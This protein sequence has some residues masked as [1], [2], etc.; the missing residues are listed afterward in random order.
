[1]SAREP[2][3]RVAI[4]CGGTGGHLFPGVAV[5]DELLKRGL[6]VTLMISPKEVDQQAAGSASGVDV[7]TLPAAGLVRGGAIKFL[8]A[9][10]ASYRAARIEFEQ[11]P[12][13]AVLAMGGFTSAPPVLAARRIHARTFLHE[14]NTIPGRAN[15]WLSWLVNG[16]FT[17]FPSA[18][19]RLH[20]RSMK[21]TGTPVRPQLKR[22]DPAACRTAL[23]VEPSRPI[24][25]VVGGSQG[26]AGIND[27]VLRMLPLVSQ[28]APGWQ[29]IHL[30]GSADF[31]KVRQAYPSARLKAIVQPFCA[32][33]NLALGAATAAVARAGAS[34]LAEFAALHLPAVLIPYPAATDNHQYFNALAF[35]EAGAA[36]ILEQKGATP[37]VL[38]Q[39]LRPLVEDAVARKA[40]QQALNGWSRPEAARDIAE[41]VMA[42]ITSR[43]ESA[44]AGR[45]ASNSRQNGVGPSS[46]EEKPG[47]SDFSRLGW[48]SPRE[49]ALRFQS[50]HPLSA[51]LRRDGSLLQ[52]VE[53]RNRA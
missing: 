19:Q 42:A 46:G 4:A 37:E 9:S 16:A 32:E 40:M 2:N 34:S 17:G 31:E 29:W 36:E 23:G 14:S 5:A 6:R 35:A 15:R 33:M 7:V 20:C 1:M 28:S 52:A 51:S 41:T 44:D 13:Q 27:L 18:A 3:Q 25:L 24:I 47:S 48:V 22:A 10:W 50:F 53:G 11:R 43:E 21:L 38:F 12:P 30:T 8:R 26:A 45:S 39:K 49:P